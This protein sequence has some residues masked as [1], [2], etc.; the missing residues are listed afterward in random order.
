MEGSRCAPTIA[1]EAGIGLKTMRLCLKW[2]NDFG[3]CSEAW[4]P[5]ALP[6]NCLKVAWPRITKRANSYGTPRTDRL[7][8]Q[9]GDHLITSLKAENFKSWVDTGDIRLAPL[10]GLF[11]SNSSGK[12][13]ILQLLLMLKQTV[14]SADRQRVLHTGDEKTYV[15]L[16]TFYD[17]V[18]GHE[19][20][21]RLYFGLHWTIPRP[22]KIANPEP[23][24][25]SRRERTLF[26]IQDMGFTAVIAGSSEGIAVEEFE[27]RF[28]SDGSDYR[29]GMKRTKAGEYELTAGDYPLRRPRGRPPILPPPVKSYGFPDQVYAYFQN[30]GF[31]SD[32][33]LAF[34]QLFNGV[35]YLGPLREDPRRSYT[36]GGERPQD[37]GRRGEQAIHALLASR[38]IKNISPGPRKRRITLEARVAQWLQKLGLIDSFS[39]EA[40]AENRREYEVRVRRTP[41]APEVLITDVGFGISQVLPVLVLCYYAPEGS[42]ILLEQPEIHLHPS[43]QAGLADLFIDVIKTRGVQILVESHSEHLLR[44][45][46]RRIAEEQIDSHDTALYFCELDREGVSHMTELELDVFGNISN[47]PTDFFGDEMG[48]LAAMTEAAMNRRIAAGER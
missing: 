15:D 40:I 4:T 38:D 44:R 37:V 28:S 29:F 17:V 7:L 1:R 22:L 32:L 33:V 35:Y 24:P 8:K 30:V 2:V 14:D 19:I 20:P 21:E 27:Y 12:S 25:Q 41:G 34:E 11:G 13:A 23:D 47:W 10:T 42:T 26:T 31:L 43:V 48:E 16:G 6:Y 9:E 3:T 46:Q 36:W 45:L 18:H 39:V 5:E